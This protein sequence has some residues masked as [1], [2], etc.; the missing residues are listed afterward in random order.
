M[1]VM[2][3]EFRRPKRPPTPRLTSAVS[4]NANSGM[5]Q[6]AQLMVLSSESNGSENN[7]S[8]SFSGVSSRGGVNAGSSKASAANAE[9][10]SQFFMPQK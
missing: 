5:W 8:P 2:P 3:G 7:R 10:S 6:L 9:K 4:Q 1:F